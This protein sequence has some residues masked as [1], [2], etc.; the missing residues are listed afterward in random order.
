MAAPVRPIALGWAIVADLAEDARAGDWVMVA[1]AVT[2]ARVKLVID[3]R[4]ADVRADVIRFYGAANVRT[5]GNTR[6][7]HDYD[8]GQC[9]EITRE[10]VE[11]GAVVVYLLG[12]GPR[13]A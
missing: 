2:D 10:R 9:V 8:Q 3:D 6:R 1:D 11:S 5:A 12:R 4:G 7:T 13:Q